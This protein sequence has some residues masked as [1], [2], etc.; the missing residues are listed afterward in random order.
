MDIALAQGVAHELANTV[1]DSAVWLSGI[2][3]VIFLAI[4]LAVLILLI[5]AIVST[6][7]DSDLTAGGKLLWVVFELWTPLLGAIAWLVV[8]RKG[9][10]NRL[11]GIDKGRARHTVPTS[12]GQHSNVAS[13]D[14]RPDQTGL[15]HA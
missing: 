8:G 9:H 12:V 5:W 6:L 4:G 14:D 10:L 15:G 7:A 3:G 1:D 13:R 2:A 11:L